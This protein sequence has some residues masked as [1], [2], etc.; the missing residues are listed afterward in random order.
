MHAGSA[1]VSELPESTPLVVGA[2]LVPSAPVL[3]VEPEALAL[4]SS[5]VVA[6]VLAVV[7][8][9]A[10]LEPVLL[11]DP[12]AL[13]PVSSPPSSLGQPDKPANKA[14][15][16]SAAGTTR[17]VDQ[18][19]VMVTRID[20]AA[21][22]WVASTVCP[23]MRRQAMLVGAWAVLVGCGGAAAGDGGG[24][25]SSGDGSGSSGATATSSAATT[26]STSADASGSGTTDGS[27]T[28]ASSTASESSAGPSSDT[29]AAVMCGDAIVAG[30][31]ACDDGNDAL[32]DGCNPDCTESFAPRWW[33]TVDS[34][35]PSPECLRN[36]A[37]NADG[38]VAAVGEFEGLAGDQNLLFGRWAPDGTEQWLSGWDSPADD[39]TAFVTDR[40]WGVALA[41]DGSVF[42]A[43]TVADAGAHAIWVSRR[44]DDGS[45]VWVHDGPGGAGEGIA[46]VALLDPQGLLWIGGWITSLGDEEA[47]LRSYTADGDVVDSF[48]IH[49]NFAPDEL[50][51]LFAD[52][53]GL[54]AAGRKTQGNHP[55]FY[56]QYQDWADTVGWVYQVDG[57]THDED[58]AY[59]VGIDAGGRVLALGY[60]DTNH[61]VLRRFPP[62]GELIELEQYDPG[63]MGLLAYD[64]VIEPGGGWILVGATPDATM[65]LA[66]YDDDGALLWS[67]EHAEPG[68]VAITA[69]AAE[70][71][72]DGSI[73][74]GGCFSDDAAPDPDHAFVA[75]FEP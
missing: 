65:W 1:P 32:G 73:V 22:T 3:S 66:R 46:N 70:R 28:H 25:S 34:A 68:T 23:S 4:V 7:L 18:A 13:A 8:A 61:P 33:T 49:G 53:V 44:A 15:H 9:V 62:D 2:P 71:R 17:W 11:L 27:G 42:V 30:D 50:Y 74:V 16:D 10:L 38:T 52:D 31:E 21:V 24:S 20:A 5:V 59:A 6:V 37:V 36:L 55:D 26:A 40:G 47:L 41:D 63:Y 67:R 43:G 12:L 48:V 51:D 54:V 19:R 72:D 60:E 29:G 58:S 35:T 56:V 57:P 39:E 69:F 64:L 45:A 14:V 75:A